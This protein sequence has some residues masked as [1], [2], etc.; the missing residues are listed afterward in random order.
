M[1]VAPLAD[2]HLEAIAHHLR[3]LREVLGEGSR[4]GSAL[5]AAEESVASLMR[6]IDADRIVKALGLPLR[7]PHLPEP[8]AGLTPADIWD[9]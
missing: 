4:Y 1:P 5:D 3:C 2:I 9:I 7:Q 8:P 6:A